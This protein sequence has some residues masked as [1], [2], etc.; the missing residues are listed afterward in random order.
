[1]STTTRN[2]RTTLRRD[3]EGRLVQSSAGEMLRDAFAALVVP[4]EQPEPL[5][6]GEPSAQAWSRTGWAIR[7]AMTRFRDAG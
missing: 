4:P 2:H 7:R 5:P 1:M 6:R 3:A